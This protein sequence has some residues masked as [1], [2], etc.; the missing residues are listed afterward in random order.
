[1]R[2]RGGREGGREKE[3]QKVRD[4]GREVEERSDHSFA[5]I[6]ANGQL[7]P[8]T[9]RSDMQ[10]NF[11]NADALRDRDMLR[12]TFNQLEWTPAQINGLRDSLYTDGVQV[13]ICLKDT[14]DVVST[15]TL[16][17]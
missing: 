15:L 12:T 1:M 3:G 13:A 2:A 8:L 4:R 7:Y 11:L 9:Y 14:G 10:S 17:I 5:A 16:Y 6:I